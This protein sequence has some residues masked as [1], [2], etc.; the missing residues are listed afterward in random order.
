[1]H[2]H[3]MEGHQ[4]REHNI[5]GVVLGVVPERGVLSR[6]Y[7]TSTS[8]L[9]TLHMHFSESINYATFPNF[10]GLFC[11]NNLLSKP[12]GLLCDF[13]GCK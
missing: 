12:V 11:G 10:A 8:S 13:S 2:D 3:D 7:S 6:R 1:M 4:L 9:Q 5:V